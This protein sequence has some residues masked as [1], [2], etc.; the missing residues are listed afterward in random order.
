M[1]NV[2][3]LTPTLYWIGGND[4]RLALFEN[5]YPIPQGVSYNSYLSLGSETI[6]FDTVD[7]AVSG[8]FFENIAHLL[9][10]RKLD[11]IIVNHMEPDHAATLAETVLR[12]PEAKIVC[13]AKTVP[14]IKQFFSFD[15][16]SRAVIVKEGD[17]LEIGG[18]TYAF[19]M[20]P[21]VHWP[22]VMVTF[23]EIGRAHV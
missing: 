21:M 15:I 23:D 18:H 9:D 5:V 6:L 7:H 8:L 10:G 17:T 20:A 13:N 14:M 11:Y 22:E 12:Y 2:K 16:D 1:Y 3:Q 19:V 4:R